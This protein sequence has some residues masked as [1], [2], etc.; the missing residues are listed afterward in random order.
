MTSELDVL[1]IVI[2]KLESA[3]IPYM[4]SGSIAANFYTIPRMT[5]D[6]DIVVQVQ[7]ADAERIYSLFSGEFYA[8]KDMIRNAV[9]E[10]SMF[11]I[12]HNEG[13][14]KVDFIVRKDSEYRKLEFVRR[15]S[16]LFE[17]TR[18]N[19]VSAE[20]LIISKLYWAKDSMSEMQI[21]DVKNLLKT[22]SGIDYDYMAKWINRLGLENIYKEV[23]K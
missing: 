13:V 16:F 7:A 8:D 10:R 15:R 3:N 22:V 9:L 19:I 12:I 23:I 2:N 21:R 11:N 17:G 5:R 18:I 6:I 4:L 20:D 14:V 1:K